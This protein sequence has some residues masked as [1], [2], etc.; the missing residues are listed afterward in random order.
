MFSDPGGF[1]GGFSGGGGGN[2]GGGYHPANQAETRSPR[3]VIMDLLTQGYKMNPQ[4]IDNASDM[5]PGMDDNRRPRKPRSGGEM[6][7]EFDAKYYGNLAPSP[8]WGINR[9]SSVLPWMNTTGG[10]ASLAGMAT[11]QRG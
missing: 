2:Y 10:L 11:Q 1:S 5:Y 4:E 6:D 9:K 7:E 3:Q 8:A